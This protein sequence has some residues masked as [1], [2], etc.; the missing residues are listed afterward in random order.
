MEPSSKFPKNIRIIYSDPYATDSSTDEEQEMNRTKNPILGFKRFVKEIT[1]YAVPFDSSKTDGK[2]LQKSCTKGV[3]RRRWGKFAAEI[4][5]PFAKKRIWL[6]TFDTAEE[7]AAAL[8]TKEREFETMKAAMYNTN[9]SVALSS[10]LS[11]LKDSA[12][13]IEME[14]NGEEKSMYV[15]KKSVKEYKFVQECKT[16][17]DK[18][19]VSVKDLWKDEASSVMVL[20]E[21]PSASDSWE[22][23]F[24]P[25]GFET[26]MPNLCDNLLLSDAV[27]DH[28][29]EDAKLIELPDMVIDNEDIAW[30]DEI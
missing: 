24:G 18:E 6:G 19:V 29:P 14:D 25:C 2:S 3:R 7:A 1:C 10:P 17:V 15:M 13:A 16:T 23:L 26:H 28:L 20:W 9:S 30:V 12:N 5:D 21:P 27:V 8:R 11:V 22:D 4:R